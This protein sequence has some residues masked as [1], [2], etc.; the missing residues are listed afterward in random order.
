MAD[1][2]AAVVKPPLAPTSAVWVQWW[3]SLIYVDAWIL[4]L[5]YRYQFLCSSDRYSVAVD[6]VVARVGVV[7]VVGATLPV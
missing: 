1:A 7:G 5:L 3:M 4:S 2:R 6:V